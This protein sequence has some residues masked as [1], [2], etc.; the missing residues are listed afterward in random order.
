M[1][2][3]P[4]TVPVGHPSVFLVYNKDKELLSVCRGRDTAELFWSLVDSTPRT[5]E[6]D[7]RN[8][9]TTI[10]DNSKKEERVFLGHF[11]EVP[12]LFIENVKK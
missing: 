6:N 12:V 2:K 9:I 11:H 8:G 5:F 7:A 4:I 10:Y 1:I 3:N